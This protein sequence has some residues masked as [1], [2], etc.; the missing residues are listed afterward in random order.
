LQGH[1]RVA[2]FSGFKSLS[3]GAR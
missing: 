2:G 1:L 3:K